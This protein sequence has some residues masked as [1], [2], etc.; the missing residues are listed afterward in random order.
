MLL[1]IPA[2]KFAMQHVC[3]ISLLCKSSWLCS[4]TNMQNEH[5]LKM[6]IKLTRELPRSCPSPPILF[7]TLSGKL[8]RGCPSPTPFLTLS[9]TSMSSKTPGRDLKDMGSLDR[10]Q[11]VGSSWNFQGCFLGVALAP[12]HHFQLCHEP[13]CL[14]RLQ[15]K[16]WR[17][18]RVLV[19]FKMFDL[20]ETFR[21]AS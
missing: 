4:S 7:S 17:T 9:G 21:D 8:P 6:T 11:D 5:H 2:E 13:P 18:W 15:E 20:H 16:T 14:P 19:G 1:L 12:W 3:K 10:V